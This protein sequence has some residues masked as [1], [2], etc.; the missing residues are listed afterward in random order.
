MTR[1]YATFAAL[2]LAWRI[3]LLPRM[4]NAASRSLPDY[5]IIGAQKGGT[6]SL[7]F[8]LGRHPQ[9]MRSLYKEVNYFERNYH[10]GVSWYRAHFPTEWAKRSAKAVTGEASP[11]YLGHREVP[12]RVR[13]LLP[14][15]RLI[16]LLR[17]PVDRM[18]SSYHHKVRLG[19]T[20][21]PFE[22]WLRRR[23]KGKNRPILA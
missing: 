7:Y 1:A 5:L 2:K 20:S 16:T 6:T 22:E 17:N 18:Y 14:D 8:L 9:V 21:L 4:W 15:C 12:S 11:S 23:Q 3:E 10:R 19:H 13:S